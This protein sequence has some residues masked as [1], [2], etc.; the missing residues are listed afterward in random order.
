MSN[1]SCCCGLNASAAT[2]PD[3][4][5]TDITAAASAAQERRRREY[6]RNA[7]APR[8]I[9]RN[10]ALSCDCR[11]DRL[12]QITRR[13][14]RLQTRRTSGPAILFDILDGDDLDLDQESG[15]GQRRD[16]NNGPCRQIGLTAAEE[17]RVTLHERLEIH[18]RPRI[19]DQKHLHLDHVADTES[20]AFQNALDFA[21][22]ADGL[23]PGI[24]I[25][26]RAAW[27]S[28]LVHDR[29][30]LAA[31]IIGRGTTRDLH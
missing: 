20:K 7:M 11:P 17:L 6:L 12:R 18:R 22:N 29:R 2:D 30:H 16:A 21:E 8:W 9:V 14:T 4:M 28:I 13:P 31:D 26:L 3:A 27:F 25:G 15:I 10:M 24:A 23:G 5:P 1:A 19:V